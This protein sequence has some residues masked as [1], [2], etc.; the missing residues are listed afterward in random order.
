MRLFLCVGEALVQA[1]FQILA[2]G[3][4]FHA[5]ENRFC[6]CTYEQCTRFGFRQSARTQIE[7]GSAVELSC[8]CTM[9]ALHI[10]GIDLELG[11]RVDFGS[12]REQQ[13]A[14]RLTRIDL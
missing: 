7:E 6:K 11:P 9:A 14:T 12:R 5:G 2:N 13:V 10:V 8:R 4:R 1:P 3:L